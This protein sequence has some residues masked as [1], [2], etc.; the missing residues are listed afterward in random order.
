MNTTHAAKMA[1]DLIRWHGLSE[2]CFD[3]DRAQVR[4]GCC[5][6]QTKTITLSYKLVS[7]NSADE[8]LNTILHEIAHALA[9]PRHGH[10]GEWRALAVS[11]GCSGARCYPREVIRPARKFKGIC[12]NGHEVLRHKR[13]KIACGKCCTMF[14]GGQFDSQFLIKWVA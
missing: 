6:F 12:P 9:G 5:H 7:S 1:V 8:V 10:G 13:N 11:I 14:S 4:F 2:W 3:W